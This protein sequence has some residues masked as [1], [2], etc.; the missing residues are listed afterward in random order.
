MEPIKIVEVG[1]EG[2]CITLFGWKT[3][4]GNW[5][6][7]R[8]TDERTL[9]GMMPKGDATGLIFRSSS[10]AVTGWKAALKILSKYPWR[11][12]YPLFVHPEFADLVWKEIENLNE[13]CYSFSKWGEVC[14]RG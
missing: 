4:K 1:A 2:G 11:E 10:E 5:R 9:L 8:E 12:L 14:G 3:N 7:L 13:E 6:F